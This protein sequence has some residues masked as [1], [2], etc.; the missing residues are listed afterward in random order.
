[1]KESFLHYIWQNGFFDQKNLRTNQGSVISIKQRGLLNT[2]AGPDFSDA[3]IIIDDL[4]WIGNIEIH[5]RSSDWYAHGHEKDPAYDNVIL[6]VVYEDN[7]PVYNSNNSQI[8]TLEL[9]KYIDKKII[10]TYNKLIKNKAILPCQNELGNIDKMLIVNFKYRL[11]TER[12]EDKYNIIKKLLIETQNDWHQIFYETLLKYIG[13]S[14]N[15]VAFELMGRLLPHRVFIKYKD[16]LIKL[17][18]LLFGVAGLL[19]EEKTDE[20]YL[21]L[22]NEFRFL[23]LKHSLNELPS[24]AVKFHRLRPSNFPTI[25]LAQFARMYYQTDHLYEK[26]LAI[27]SKEQAYDILSATASGYWDTHYNFDK[28]TKQKKKS[29]GQDFMNLMLINVII[30]LKFAYQ[31]HVGVYN[32][33]KLFDLIESIP[34]EKNK[35]VNIFNKINLPARNALDTQAIL[36][37]NKAYCFENKCLSCDIGHSIL[38]QGLKNEF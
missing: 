18:A 6:H 3:H 24:G 20:Y 19:N 32:S 38:K 31:K 15:K 28:Q 2:D 16:N 22:Q 21:L 34:P 8:P 33:E 17:E 26:L 37:L 27:N 10:K 36:Q 9:S 4:L 13:G 29:T 30:P 14:V 35:I 11:F 5:K 1:M 12:L 25:R 23:K 7:M